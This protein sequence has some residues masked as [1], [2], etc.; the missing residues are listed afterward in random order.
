MIKKEFSQGT[1]IYLSQ[2]ALDVIIEALQTMKEDYELD[3]ND[4]KFTN[5]LIEYLEE[6]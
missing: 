5:A 4:L 3:N 6:N 2:P 1:P